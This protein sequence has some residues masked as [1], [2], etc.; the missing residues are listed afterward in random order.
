M[1]R[2]CA[3][4]MGTQG[5]QSEMYKISKYDIFEKKCVISE[6]HKSTVCSSVFYY[7]SRIGFWLLT[8]LVLPM[9][10]V[11]GALRGV[12]DLQRERG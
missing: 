7:S 2:K 9:M 5:G 3:Y 8:A 12:R 6:A 10:P 11:Y 1:Q 4:T